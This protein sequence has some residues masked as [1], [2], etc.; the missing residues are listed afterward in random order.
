MLTPERPLHSPPLEFG[1]LV[2]TMDRHGVEYLLVGGSAAGLYGA[3]R[4]T[5]DADWV[6]CRERANLDRLA[7]AL[8]G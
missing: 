5:E 1:K 3:E 8:R 2:E 7:G 4:P 6:V